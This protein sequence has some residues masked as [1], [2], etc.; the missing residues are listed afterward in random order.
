MKN[1][2]MMFFLLTC[3]IC[4]AQEVDSSRFVLIDGDTVNIFQFWKANRCPQGFYHQDD[5][6]VE[7]DS[8][9]N[10]RCFSFSF[11]NKTNRIACKQ[12]V[13]PRTGKDSVI[14]IIYSDKIDSA[15]NGV[16]ALGIDG[17]SF[18]VELSRPNDEWFNPYNPIMFGYVDLKK[19]K[20]YLFDI[21][22]YAPKSGL[23]DIYF[24]VF[25]F[26]KKL[27]LF[28]FDTWKGEGIDPGSTEGLLHPYWDS[29]TSKTKIIAFKNGNF[30]ELKIHN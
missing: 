1:L 26:Y 15:I 11:D 19:N 24:L 29:P 12:I 21:N 22:K 5:L 4:N 27:P 30:E 13:N 3:R 2:L 8:N 28:Y 18:W 20:T 25:G 23:E 16:I 7:N 9:W 14:R 10:G 6:L 17:V